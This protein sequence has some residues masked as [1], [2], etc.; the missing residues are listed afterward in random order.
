MKRERVP[1][2]AQLPSLRLE[3]LINQL[4]RTLTARFRRPRAT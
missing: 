2:R 1:E 3:G 4:F